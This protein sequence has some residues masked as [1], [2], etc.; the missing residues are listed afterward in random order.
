M[1]N[2]QLFE[3]M[4]Q[5]ARPDLYEIYK[6][7]NDVQ[8]DSMTVLKYLNLIKNVQIV[9]GWGKVTTLIQNKAVKRVDQEQGYKI[10]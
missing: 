8:V 6:L 10:D 4:L 1:S 2:D 7:M 5:K 3:N 9:S